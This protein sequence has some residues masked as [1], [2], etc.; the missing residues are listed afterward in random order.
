MHLK[1]AFCNYI[2]LPSYVKELR[3]NS[4][5]RIEHNESV[6]K[7][8]WEWITSNYSDVSKRIVTKKFPDGTS[9]CAF[10]KGAENFG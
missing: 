6:V 5:V 4:A 1:V 8:L 2:Y 10:L 9:N 3:E 7:G